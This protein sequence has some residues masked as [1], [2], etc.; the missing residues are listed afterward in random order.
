MDQPVLTTKEALLAHGKRLF[1][2]EGYGNVSVRDITG[3]AG[4]DAALVS[5]YFGGKLGLF[6]A[7]LAGMEMLDVSTI[8][9]AEALIDALVRIFDEAERQADVPT[10]ISLALSNARDP[11]A[12]PLVMARLSA[13]WTEPMAQLLSSKE[14]AAMVTCVVFGLSVGEKML[15]IDGIHAPGTP[16]YRAQVEHMLRAALA[17]P[18]VTVPQGPVND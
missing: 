9:D 6:E 12:G 14:L 17:T 15:H 3:A 4:V 7:T 2:L 13:C 16:E 11:E 8:P 1:W 10:A 18:T 5:R